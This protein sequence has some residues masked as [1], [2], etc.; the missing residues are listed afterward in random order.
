MT[1]TRRL[2]FV[3]LVVVMTTACVSTPRFPEAANAWRAG[4]RPKALALA[5]AE[6]ER[7][8]VGNSL[9]AQAI[10]NALAELSEALRTMPIALP[11]D[12]M[13]VRPDELDEPPSGESP[14]ARP[15]S[16]APK[17]APP[18]DLEG[19]APPLFRA[20]MESTLRKD[21]V[22]SGALRVVR[23]TRSVMRL[24]MDRFGVELLAVCFR[25]DAFT[26]DHALVASYPTALRSLVVKFAALDALEELTR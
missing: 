24:G 17:D 2:S 15:K 3:L 14:D 1:P 12:G 6:V 7:F 18:T 9:D 10:T 23:A 4:E 21:L 11:G 13:P 16:P 5:R 19:R 26:S 22:A 25:R 20:T 8:R